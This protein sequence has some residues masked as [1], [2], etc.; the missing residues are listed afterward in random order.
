MIIVTGAAG[1]IGSCIV[2]KL[3][4]MGIDDLVLVDH[5]PDSPPS[6][7]HE[8]EDF[9]E[10]MRLKKKNLEN[11]KYKDYL[12][13]KE[14][15][16]KVQAGTFTKDIECIIHMGAC[17]ST[18]LN[19]EEYYREN[20]FFYSMIIAKWA[21]KNRIKFIYA[22]SAATYGKGDWGY[23]DDF[24]TM[25]L[26]KPLNLYAKSKHSFDN[27]LRNNY[28]I[29]KVVGLKFFN[30]FGPNEYHKGPMR[31]VIAKSFP[32]IKEEGRISLFKSYK[33][34]YE[35]G[36]QK[37]DFIYIKD[38]LDIIEFFLENEYDRGIFNAG[39]GKARTWN[40][41]AKAMFNAL[42][43]PVCIDYVEMPE[44]LRKNYQYF[45]EATTEK[46]REAGY[47]KDFWTLEDAIKDYVGYLEEGKHL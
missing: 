38:V 35:H 41:L 31:S 19:D 3:N 23:R 14:F 20:N 30:V 11:K 39:T 47:Q 8:G 6:T 42:N 12:D 27:W 32:K 7:L 16:D 43:K 36:D 34:E 15:F 2:W 5:F 22:S 4:S 33:G 28:H 9:D 25:N 46:L 40:D 10:K 18:I 45:T 26:I 21:V 24:N 44:S 37:R 17:S 1:F 13:K 29:Y